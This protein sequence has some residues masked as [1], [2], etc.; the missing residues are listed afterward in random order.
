MDI[1]RPEVVAEV[2]EAFRAY[3]AALT[4]NDIEVLDINDI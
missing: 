2:T 4:G 1:N 3:E